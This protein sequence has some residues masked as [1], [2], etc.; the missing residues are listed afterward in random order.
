M[1]ILKIIFYFQYF[2][3]EAVFNGFMISQLNLIVFLVFFL[4]QVYFNKVNGKN[5]NF[6][7]QLNLLRQIKYS[8][9]SGSN[10]TLYLLQILST[11]V[12]AMAEV[13]PQLPTAMFC[14]VATVSGCLSLLLPE[15]DGA[16]LPDT[17]E[18]SEEVRLVPPCRVCHCSD[19]QRQGE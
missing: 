19:R 1:F 17:A 6:N 14:L 4:K 18:Q 7:K 15:T 12:T 13:S 11:T 2:I 9:F 3:Y 10:R 5:V 8:L 16:V